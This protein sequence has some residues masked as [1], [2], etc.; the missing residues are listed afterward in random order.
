MTCVDYS[1]QKNTS[2][3]KHHTS[4]IVRKK[5]ASASVPRLD[6]NHPLS[7]AQH[8][9]LLF[10]FFPLHSLPRRGNGSCMQ[11][12]SVC[13]DGRSAL[14]GW[15]NS[16]ADVKIAGCVCQKAIL[17]AVVTLWRHWRKWQFDGFHSQRSMIFTSF[18]PLPF[19]HDKLKH[20][21]TNHR[22]DAGHI[23]AQH[24]P[25][26]IRRIALAA[27]HTVTWKALIIEQTVRVRQEPTA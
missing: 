2:S 26:W 6:T 15:L 24:D 4:K 16:Y 20:L 25:K 19:L 12:I 21:G 13:S 17:L 18:P 14:I 9:F 1:D 10:P 27:L 22:Q 3:N 7:Q 23:T 11:V 8:S 5:D